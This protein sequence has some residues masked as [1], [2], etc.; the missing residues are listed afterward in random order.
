M[1][2]LCLEASLPK[3]TFY[4]KTSGIWTVF[5]K[6][7][8]NAEYLQTLGLND[9]QVKAVLFA[10]DKRRITN[11][12]YQEINKTS[13]RTA[14]RDLDSLVNSNIFKREGEKKGVFY[15]VVDGANGV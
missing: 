11:K 5:Q 9:R 1:T 15:Q 7:I 10:K 13:A 2:N 12:E 4:Y 3:P 8:L 14:V 6:D